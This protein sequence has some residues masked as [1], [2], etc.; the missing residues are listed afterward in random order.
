MTCTKNHI[1]VPDKLGYT[2]FHM[3][4]IDYTQMTMESLKL[5]HYELN[6]AFS[7]TH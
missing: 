7:I 2:S 1:N 4:Q 6:C 3:I 5:E